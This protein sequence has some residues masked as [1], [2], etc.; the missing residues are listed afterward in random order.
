MGR[1]A[2]LRRIQQLDP[3][4]DHVAIYQLMCGYDFPWDQARAFELAL[5]RTYCIPGISALLDRS[6][7]F[8]NYTQKRYDDTAIIV[9][10]LTSFGYDS[11]RG[12]AALRR[13]NRIHKHFPINNDDYLYVLSV[14]IYEP[15]RWNA[16]FGWRKMCRQERLAAYYFWREIGRRMN[17]KDIPDS[18]EAFAQWSKVYEREQFRFTSSN[19]RI[20][21]ATRDL[22]LSWFPLPT[23]ARKALRPATYALLDDAMLAAFGFPRPPMLLRAALAAALKTRAF[24]LHFFPPRAKRYTVEDTS[25][26]LYPGGYRLTDIGPNSMLADLN[27]PWHEEAMARKE[28]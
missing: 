13:M 22:F 6:G 26:R 11:E 16:R 17:I 3:Q 4:K 10:E 1:Y 18:F 15:I 7:E 23:F 5:F 25:F 2:I 20:G 19:Q 27:D 8:A 21:E 9:A 14:F 12:R 28:Q 24:I